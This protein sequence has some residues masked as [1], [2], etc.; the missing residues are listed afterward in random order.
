MNNKTD[1]TLKL[2][3]A[4]KKAARMT[5][6]TEKDA[7]V[8]A[9]FAAEELRKYLLAVTGVRL[10]VREG[11]ESAGRNLIILGTRPTAGRLNVDLGADDPELDGFV[12]RTVDTNLLLLGN[13]GRGL[14]Y[15]VYAFL[16]TLGIAWLEPGLKNEQIPKMATLK[17]GALDLRETPAFKYRGYTLTACGPQAGKHGLTLETL[18]KPQLLDMIDWIAKQRQNWLGL[19]S[20]R[21]EIESRGWV[22]AVAG[23]MQKRG[24]LMTIGGHSWVNGPYGLGEDWTKDPENMKYIAMHN[25]ERK[26]PA[27][28]NEEGTSAA[29]AQLC[30]SNDTAVNKVVRNAVAYLKANP[31]YDIL[32]LFASD[33]MNEWCECPDCLRDSPTDLYLKV[34]LA[35]ARETAQRLPERKVLFAAYNDVMLPPTRVSLASVPENLIL[36]FCRISCAKHVFESP[37]CVSAKP[38]QFSFPRNKQAIPEP[39]NNDWFRAVLGQWQKSY[40]G[41]ICMLDYGRWYGKAPSPDYLL[42]PSLEITKVDLQCYRRL[43]LAG[44]VDVIHQLFSLPN[45]LDMYLLSALNW[46]P[47]LD[48]KKATAAYYRQFYG[49]TGQKAERI[50]LKV[51]QSIAKH[52][53]DG[54]DFKVIEACG[55]EWSKLRA[56]RGD[57]L[58]QERLRR[59]GLYLQY[60]IIKKH[61]ANS[62]K[63]KGANDV[64]REL[65]GIK[66][67]LTKHQKALQPFYEVS[68]L[69]AL[70]PNMSSK[71]LPG[72]SM[73][74]LVSRAMPGAGKLETLAY[75][76]NRATLGFKVRVFGTY[77]ERPLYDLHTDL[78][79]S[80]SKDVLVYFACPFQC[81]ESMKLDLCLGYDGPV[82][83]WLDGKLICHD[84]NG[85]NPAV[86][87]RKVIPIDAVKG[88]HEVIIAM[89]SNCGK[90]W[91]MFLRFRRRQLPNTPMEKEIGGKLPRLLA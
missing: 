40:A 26:L 71:H 69:T 57:R 18:S 91:G 10:P 75:P 21:I 50:L 34:I 81:S 36:L 68:D 56:P 78:F 55:R 42:Y 22:P 73:R 45:A 47:D 1:K 28:V 7:S 54:G 65:A 2:T 58:L 79:K 76:A 41:P 33:T 31:Q 6:V 83:V 67:F 20:S 90:A 37:D 19:M 23:A 13:N 86:P 72:C 27:Y 15:S 52:T 12:V 39:H 74:V 62:Q 87:D 46:N 70:L 8:T 49:A 44:H 11:G 38:H 30:A 24:M 60:V 32:A 53:A 14:L 17:I 25:G 89:G 80:E 16:E 9:R 4:E 82:K 66:Q 29:R 61:F 88:R 77:Q 63:T 35:L 51:R 84:P 3:I 43:G 64:L 48:L 85:T 59:A 5:I